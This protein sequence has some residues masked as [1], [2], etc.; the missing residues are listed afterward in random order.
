MQRFFQRLFRARLDVMKKWQ[1]CRYQGIVYEVILGVFG[2]WIKFRSCV[3][4][5][6]YT[7][8]SHICVKRCKEV[9]R[10]QDPL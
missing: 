4:D 2:S 1:L 8:R 10:K 7:D 6:I 3:I 9:Y 5:K